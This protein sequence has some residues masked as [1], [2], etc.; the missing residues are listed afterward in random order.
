MRRQAASS[1]FY[2][3]LHWSWLIQAGKD[4]DFNRKKVVQFDIAR[5]DV[6]QENNM[7]RCYC[8]IWNLVELDLNI[9]MIVFYF[10]DNSSESEQ[11]WIKNNETPS[12]SAVYKFVLS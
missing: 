3:D 5:K 10:H 11:M 4:F 6:E 8:R 1:F 12:T 7:H 2:D 9:S